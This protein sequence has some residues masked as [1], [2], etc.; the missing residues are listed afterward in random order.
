MSE[1]ICGKVLCP[2]FRDIKSQKQKII[3]EGIETD[4]VITIAFGK[5]ESM[6]KYVNRNCCNQY[7]KCLIAQA[8]YEKY[9]NRGT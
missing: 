1:F 2:F 9:E 7:D 6:R 8:L 5:K 3:C 4:S